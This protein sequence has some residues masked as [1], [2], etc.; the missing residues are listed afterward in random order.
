[1][2]TGYLYKWQPPCSCFYGFHWDVIC[3]WAGVDCMAG[4]KPPQGF[5][6]RLHSLQPM[7]AAAPSYMVYVTSI[8]YRHADRACTAGFK[9]LASTLWPQLDSWS[10]LGCRDR[11][12]ICM[13]WEPECMDWWETIVRLA[14]QVQTSKSKYTFRIFVHPASSHRSK[15]QKELSDWP[16]IMRM[17]WWPVCMGWQ[18]AIPKLRGPEWR[19]QYI[20]IYK[21]IYIYIHSMQG[22]CR[23]GSVAAELLEIWG[24]QSPVQ[25]D[26]H[27]KDLYLQEPWAWPL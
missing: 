23:W 26:S 2:S 7:V 4:S 11:T 10:D 6:C 8:K 1:M 25:T 19:K 21:Y 13:P 15:T 17:K 22:R 20:Y 24:L 27:Q 18:I 3:A 14:L 9:Q 12:H 16:S 5:R